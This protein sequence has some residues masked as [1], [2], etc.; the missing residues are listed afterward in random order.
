MKSFKIKK[1]I[2][3]TIAIGGLFLRSASAK[4]PDNAF[5]V[6]EWGTFTSVQ[7]SE[8]K[9]LEGLHHEEEKLPS[10]VK[11]R[12]SKFGFLERQMNFCKGMSCP[13]SRNPQTAGEVIPKGV[14]QKMETPV[15]YFYSP[16]EREV[17]VEVDFPGGILSQYYPEPALELPR[18]GNVQEL[19]NGKNVYELKI[20]KG[21]VII[22]KVV[23]G[24]GE[25]Y[26]PARE[27]DANFLENH[28]GQK[29]RLVFYRGLGKFSLP[30]Q[31]ISKKENYFEI[32]N[33]GNEKLKH[34]LLLGEKN[35]KFHLEELP[36]IAAQ[37]SHQVKTP[38]T[39][40]T[41]AAYLKEAKKM[42]L[43]SLEESGLYAKEA[44]AMF[45]TWEQHYLKTP[46]LR[47]LY[48]IPKKT[49][50]EILPLKVTPSPDKLSR[51]MVAR[52][53]IFSAK[54]ERELKETLLEVLAKNESLELKDL[55]DLNLGTL[56]EAKLDKIAPTSPPQL[57]EA[58]AEVVK[59][60]NNTSL[61]PFAN[62]FGLQEI[63][64]DH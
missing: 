34:A 52:V 10:F 40:P 12:S 51:V 63:S 37:K 21:D 39:L 8:G 1:S 5:V 17:S 50:E 60:L 20:H 57:K 42:I 64:P 35:G 7:D 54:E 30:V 62:P 24:D 38:T 16:T 48:I 45:N 18:I 58:I 56:A 59:K 4:A 55:K 32:R 31:V 19:A 44:L 33:T 43:S 28:K 25:I 46:G 2:I 22:P 11:G 36:T 49:V 15:L 41:R 13:G 26:K 27:V 29:D 53:E 61:F 14:T 9:E 6:H 3:L 47:L 23:R